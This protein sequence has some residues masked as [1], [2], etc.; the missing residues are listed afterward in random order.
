MIEDFLQ[1]QLK[2]V[3]QQH[4]EAIMPEEAKAH[5]KFGIYKNGKSGRVRLGFVLHKTGAITNVAVVESSG[6]KVMDSAAMT[7][8]R[9]SQPL[10]LPA[11]FSKNELKVSASFYYNPKSRQW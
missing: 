4:W 8:I 1:R 2:P 3:V 9:E 6:D 5:R 10:R 7:A 11:R